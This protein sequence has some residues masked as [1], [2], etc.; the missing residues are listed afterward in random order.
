MRRSL[1][2]RWLAAGVAVAMTAMACAQTDAGL[3]T[4]V[5]T[6]LAADDTVKAYQID[7]DTKEKVVTLT[8]TVD[9]QAAKDQA[10][11][12]AR[13]TAGVVDVVD[14]IT[15][16]GAGGSMEGMGEPAMGTTPAMEGMPGIATTPTAVTT[17]IMAMT[18]P[19][20]RK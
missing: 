16:S 3:T 2:S 9:N 18:T 4:K 10:I 15:V 13:S 11:S 5:K 6:K 1:R 20:P 14:N 19:G 7:V 12:L 17:P 8:G